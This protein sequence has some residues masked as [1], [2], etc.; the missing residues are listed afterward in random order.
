MCENL[1]HVKKHA[2]IPQ[3]N[4]QEMAAFARFLRH[5]TARFHNLSHLNN[6]FKKINV[7]IRRHAKAIKPRRR[8]LQ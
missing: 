6:N 8:Y 2:I 3:E 1:A 5:F 4:K 7:E